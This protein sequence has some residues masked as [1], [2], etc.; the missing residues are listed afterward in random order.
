MKIRLVTAKDVLLSLEAVVIIPTAGA[1]PLSS[2]NSSW[3]ISFRQLAASS[4][5]PALRK[6]NCGDNMKLASVSKMPSCPKPKPLISPPAVVP[7]L[8]IPTF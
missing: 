1:V 3:V 4:A 6:S 5:L 7:S 2:V 8:F